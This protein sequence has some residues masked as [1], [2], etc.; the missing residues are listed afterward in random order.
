LKSGGQQLAQPK[1]G[2]VV[3]DL[4][5]VKATLSYGM[6]VP[7]VHEPGVLHLVSLST[8]VGNRGNPSAGH[9]SQ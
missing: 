3:A 2:A 4:T 7:L 1:R 9:G 8:F 6:L 5:T